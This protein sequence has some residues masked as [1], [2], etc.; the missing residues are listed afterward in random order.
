MH[1]NKDE[2]VGNKNS[3]CSIV[4]YIYNFSCPIME[5]MTKIKISAFEGMESSIYI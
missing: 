3:T 1:I 2:C 4:R 5:L